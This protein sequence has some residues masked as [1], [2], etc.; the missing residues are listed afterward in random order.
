MSVFSSSATV[1]LK[2]LVL[3]V[4]SLSVTY[5]QEKPLTFKPGLYVWRAKNFKISSS[6]ARLVR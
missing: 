5:A 3:I 2:A 4:I 1:C 6:L